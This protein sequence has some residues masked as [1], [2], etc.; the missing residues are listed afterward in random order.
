MGTTIITKNGSGAP[1]ASDLVAGELAVDLTNKRLYTE[2]S[3][4]NILELGSNPSTIVVAG[5]STLTGNVTA[6]NDVS[7]GGNLTVTGNATI[8]GNLTF[9]NAATDTIT[10][11]ADV[12]SSI[13][14]SADDTYDLG[15]TA[16]R[17]RD[18]Y[19]DGTAYLDAINFNG[20]AITATAAEL[21]ILDG[22]TSTA[23]ELNILDGVTSTA[24]EL[25]IL[26]GVTSTAAEL[27]LVDGSS[28]GTIV[29]SK[30]VVYGASG[31]VNAT[32][33]Q[34]AGT[35][36]T[37]TAA[38][39]NIL[40]GVTATAA[41]LNILDGVTST[42]AELNILDGVTSTAAELNLLDG[43]TATTAELNYLDVTTLGT[44]E[45]SKAVTA[46][47]N[48][49]VKFGDSDK[50]VFG[51]DSDLQIYHDGSNSYIVDNGTGDLLIRAENN[52][53]LK[54]TNSD[55]TYLSG[56][57]N[58]AVT[59]FHNNNAKIATTISGI[60]VTGT[61]TAD[62]LT[63][64]GSWPILTLNDTRN[65]NTWADGDVV[66]ELKFTTNDTGMTNP[67]A[68]IRA[69]HDR[70]GT[71]HSSNDAGLEFYTSATTT[72]TIA[73]RIE[74]ESVTG[75]ISFYE[76]TGTTAKFYWDASAESLGIGTASPSYPLHVVKNSAGQQSI[77]LSNNDTGTS[78]ASAF[79]ASNGTNEIRL[80]R[81]GTSY[82]SYG[83]FTSSD[84]ALYS[85]N[86]I[87]LMADNASGIIKFATG[88]NSE[89]MRID[90]SGNVLI[91]TTSGS[92]NLVVKGSASGTIG[93][94]GAA[95]GNQ[96][97]AFAQA[98]TDKAFLT[99]WDSSDTLALTDGSANGLH[100]SPS[101]GNVGIGTSSPDAQGG[102]QSTILNLEGSDNIVYFSGGSGGNAVDDGLAIEGVA[103][104]VSSG[105]KRTGSILMTRANTSTTSLDSKITFY[106]TSSG[107][108][109]ERMRIDS[110]GDTTFKTSAGHLSVEAL[111][112][113]SVLLNSNGSLG[114]N[115]AS[116]FNYEI[117]VGGSE[118][119]RINSSG[120]LMLGTTSEVLTDSSGTGLY[121]DV[122]KGS[123][124]LKSSGNISAIMNRVASDGDIVQFRKDGTTVGSIGVEGGDSLYIQSGTTSGSGLHF[125]PTRE[126]IT[127]LRNGA[128][129]DDEISLGEDSRRFKDLYLSGS[130]QLTSGNRDTGGKGGALIVGGNSDSNGL[131]TNTRKIGLITCPSYD[132][133]DGNMALIT[134][135]TSS[136]SANYI[137]IGSAYTGYSSPTDIIFRTGS[138]GTIGSERIRIDSSGNLLIGQSSTTT[139]GSGNTTSGASIRAGGS[140]FFSVDQGPA[141]YLSRNGDT[142]AILVFRDDNVEV[143][144]VS[145]T[146][147]GVAYNTSSDQRL[148]ENIVDAPSASDDI[149]AIQVRS[150]DWKADGAHQKYGMVA[151]ELVTVAPNAVS[152]PEDP[153]EMMGVDYSKLV[154]MLIKEV[155]QLRA[156]VAQLEGEN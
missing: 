48:A 6:S 56:A 37:S 127:P 119:M 103:T 87:V 100:F 49:D 106:T 110:S 107:T 24:A 78:A 45:A 85:D 46:D 4:A 26:D 31:E 27:N 130:A 61:V 13:V 83:S 152:Q 74:I 105:D 29:N 64:D 71:G 92:R 156:R 134:G 14:P 15:A 84:G 19:I 41:E 68:S 149:D 10:L 88:G 2:D 1:A 5:T 43:V 65:I 67:I 63:V 38:E 17:W 62:G 35:S 154:P 33:L 99:Y 117:D 9:G 7:V 137:Y 151:Q 57:V 28:A 23:A 97:I 153:E 121:Y 136:A 80:L 58:G 21:N 20:T 94:D 60:D 55:E 114:M 73:K 54:R 59:L 47:A 89:R 70:A 22:V 112:G 32:T 90:S 143:G 113:G 144:T 142:G 76:D 102:N 122:S 129:V 50:L 11:T 25:N 53:F 93:I 40:D 135:D 82:S 120:D 109:A 51:A 141:Q 75:D 139:P 96:Q 132:N 123:L 77:V 150:F 133:T 39:L 86:S 44:V 12:A 145:T 81:A 118:V 140:T 16:S 72:G 79:I 115:V 111:G 155:Q 148:K 146:G 69:V 36:I 116:G 124:Q 98:G 138:V 8:E 52:L 18:I 101:T 95:T 131:T 34:I 3:S 108:H 126:A 66:G 42:A 91:G 30:A 147:S 125:H 104:G 128:R